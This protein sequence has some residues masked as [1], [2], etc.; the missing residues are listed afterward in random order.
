MK[1]IIMMI[2]AL[3]V[4]SVSFA[5][6]EDPKVGK[7]ILHNHEPITACVRIKEYNHYLWY[8]GEVYEYK[9]K[10]ITHAVVVTSFIGTESKPGDFEDHSSSCNTFLNEGTFIVI[11]MRDHKFKKN[12]GTVTF[13]EPWV[14]IK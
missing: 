12:T 10:K 6:A 9:D 1:R 2:I 8:E 3:L 11:H 14:T 13:D 7:P 5:V 4:V